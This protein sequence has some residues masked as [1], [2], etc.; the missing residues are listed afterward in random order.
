MLKQKV[1]APNTQIFIIGLLLIMFGFTAWVARYSATLDGFELTV[2]NYFYNASDNL[3]LIALTVT[4][5]G[6][7]WFLVLL[8]GMFFV[9]KR[10]PDPALRVMRAGVLTFGAA[11]VAKS[12][13]GRPRPSYLL[14]NVVLREVGVRGLGFPSAHTAL[15]TAV[16][17]TLLPYLPR[18]WRWLPI[19]WIGLVAWSRLYLGAHTPL[20]ILGGFLLGLLVAICASYI[21]WWGVEN[22]SNR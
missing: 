1:F 19:P 2:F 10:R 3:W 16:S 11:V 8:I 15:A 5:L 13:V 14:E 22:R 17:L 9:V 21:P 18:K 7:I 20:D 6:S 4:Q 12:L